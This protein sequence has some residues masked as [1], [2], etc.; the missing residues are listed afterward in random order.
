MGTLGAV[1]M[2]TS[3][4]RKTTFVA[5]LLFL[6]AESTLVQAQV[7]GSSADQGQPG[8]TRKEPPGDSAQLAG[9]ARRAL[10]EG[11]Y[12]S[13]IANLERLAKLEPGAAEVHADLGMA[14]YFVGQY[15]DAIGQCREALN[16]KH[17]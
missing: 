16:S 3:E 14:Y 2:I 4:R 15:D 13:A 5:L 7:H 8:A 6:S 11:D 10:S 17:R 12:A 1:R 9:E